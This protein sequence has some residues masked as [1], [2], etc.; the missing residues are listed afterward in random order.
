MVRQWVIGP[1]NILE[2][3]ENY[4]PMEAMYLYHGIG[5]GSK[6]LISEI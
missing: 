2:K 6:D 5:S 1:P 4:V 3:C